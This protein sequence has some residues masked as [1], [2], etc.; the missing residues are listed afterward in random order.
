M[1]PGR[2]VNN[3]FERWR[4]TLETKDFRLNRSKT[5]SSKYQFSEGKGGTE[6]VVTLGSVWLYQGLK[7]LDV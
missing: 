2:G 6:D 7:W 1:R 4:D 5:E 3:K